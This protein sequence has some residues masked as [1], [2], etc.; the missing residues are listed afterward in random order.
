MVAKRNASAARLALGFVFELIT[1]PPVTRL[2]RL[3]PNQEA[4]WLA[5]SH[6]VISVPNLT[7]DFQRCEPVHA[8]DPGQVHPRHPVQVALDIEAGRVSLI[9]FLPLGAGSAPSLRSSTA[10]VGCKG[11]R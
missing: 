7:D 10:P 8:V 2:S 6:F 4:K 11:R 9:A 5:L 3:S 1:L